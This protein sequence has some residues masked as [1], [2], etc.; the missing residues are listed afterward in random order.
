MSV[1]RSP[2]AKPEGKARSN[3][4]DARASLLRV[5]PSLGLTATL[6]SGPLLDLTF[7]ERAGA[8]SRPTATVFSTGTFVSASKSGAFQ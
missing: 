8:L 7:C 5:S 2:V 6:T 1:T 3:F 4:A